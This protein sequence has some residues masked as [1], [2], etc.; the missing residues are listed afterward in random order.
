MRLKYLAINLPGA[1]LLTEN[2]HILTDNTSKSV[3]SCL[4]AKVHS[5][6]THGTILSCQAFDRSANLRLLSVNGSRTFDSSSFVFYNV[7]K[8]WRVLV[9]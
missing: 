1:S 4:V 8:L 7:N 9:I 5:T 6:R 2:Y 3:K